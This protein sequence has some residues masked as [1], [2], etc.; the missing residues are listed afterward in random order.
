[1]SSTA[2][3]QNPAVRAD[4]LPARYAI[5]DHIVVQEPTQLD[6]ALEAWVPLIS[7][8]PSQ[9]VLD[10]SIDANCSWS[11]AREIEFGN[12]VLHARTSHAQRWPLRVELRYLVERLPVAQVLHPAC[13]RPLAT[14]ELF[15]RHLA[16][17][18]FVDVNDRTRALADEIV[19]DE[20]NAL[21]Q[22]KQIYRYVTGTMTY[23]AA[24]QS[25]KGSTEHALVCAAGNC[26]RTIERRLTFAEE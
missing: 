9:R 2:E 7:D 24:K 21:E 11:V 18:E 23:D 3:R 15:A 19:G 5:R 12:Q 17:E 1:M 25:W 10:T 14:P 6:H 26:N 4:T 16:P 22:V 20:R 8:T 13:A